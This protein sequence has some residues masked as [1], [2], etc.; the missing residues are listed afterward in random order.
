MNDHKLINE[1]CLPKM[2]VNDERLCGTSLAVDISQKRWRT[3]VQADTRTHFLSG[4]I[5]INTA[6]RDKRSSQVLLYM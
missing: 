3:S 6:F 4:Y 2:T 5:K 1:F